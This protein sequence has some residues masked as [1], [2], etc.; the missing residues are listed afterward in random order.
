M[1]ATEMLDPVMETP[2]G[3]PDEA[4]TPGVDSPDEVPAE[5]TPES[6]GS[7]PAPGEETPP[8]PGGEDE[9]D[10]PGVGA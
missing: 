2:E 5:D 1:S 8:A 7:E 3:P 10:E 4:E 6:P 9:A